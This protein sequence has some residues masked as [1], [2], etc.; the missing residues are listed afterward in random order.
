MKK[1]LM[2]LAILLTFAVGA[3]AQAPT[4][5]SIYAGGALSLP[6][7][8][9]SFKEGFKTGYHGL[10]GLGFDL[11]PTLELVG[12]FEYHA[13]KVDFD[14]S[15]SEYSG[16]TNK[17]MMF[18]ADAKWNPSLP[19]LPISPYVLGGIG[20]A[21]IKQ[22]EFDGPPSM[23][24][25]FMNEMVQEDQ[26]EFYWNLGGGMEL[27]T[28]PMLSLFAQVRWVQIQTEGEASSF[29]PVSIGLKFF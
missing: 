27:A 14:E 19:A 16:G 13:F 6:T 2:V 15:M 29:V 22:S 10:L 20:F 11:M 21:N 9:D 8:P 28:S 18:G 23:A 4:P 12:K 1:V 5:F 7:A 24:L 3:S 26:T 25:S 17:L